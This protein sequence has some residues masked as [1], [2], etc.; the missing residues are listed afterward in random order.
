MICGGDHGSGAAAS[1]VRPRLFADDVGMFGRGGG[2]GN[3]AAADDLTAVA[4][5]CG[6]HYHAVRVDR[7][8]ESGAAG[9]SE[10]ARAAAPPGG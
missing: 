5:A 7:A 2:G 4:A 9:M 1:V 3:G 6:L 10:P 8:Q